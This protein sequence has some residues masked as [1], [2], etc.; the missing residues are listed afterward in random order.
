MLLR[1]WELC[2]LVPKVLINLSYI[3]LHTSVAINK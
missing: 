2:D 1:K 3:S